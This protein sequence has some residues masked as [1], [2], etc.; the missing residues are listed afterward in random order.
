MRGFVPFLLVLLAL[1]IMLR[2]EFFFSIF[3]LFAG[4]YLL[5]QFWIG[6]IKR[7][8]AVDRQFNDHVFSGESVTV[9]LTLA[10]SSWL[11]VPWV[12]VVETLPAELTTPWQPDLVHL[13]PQDRQTLRFTFMARRR[14]YFG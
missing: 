2:I 7:G 5:S 6:R 1:A 4:L 3:Y 10:N 11:P 12:E 14:G 13:G 9:E 8:L